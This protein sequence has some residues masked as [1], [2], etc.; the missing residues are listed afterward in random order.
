MQQKNDGNFYRRFFLII[1]M[2]LALQNLYNLTRNSINNS[3]HIVNPSAPTAAKFPFQ[4]FRLSKS[5]I[6]IALYI[7]Q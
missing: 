3:I 2:P 4:G 6:S 1:I 5:T 7:L